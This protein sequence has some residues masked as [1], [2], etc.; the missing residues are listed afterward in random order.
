MTKIIALMV[1]T[2]GLIIAVYYLTDYSCR[3]AQL[4]AH[5]CRDLYGLD[6]NCG[7]K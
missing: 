2:I 4:N 5:Y 6:E 1:V 3:M 7:Q